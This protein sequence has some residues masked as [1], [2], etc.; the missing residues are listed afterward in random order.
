MV[1]VGLVICPCSLCPLVLLVWNLGCTSSTLWGLLLGP[2]YL[3][4]CWIWL[5][6]VQDLQLCPYDHLLFHVQ[7]FSFH[8]VPITSRMVYNP[9]LTM[10]LSRSWTLR[11]CTKILLREHAQ[12][13]T[14]HLHSPQLPSVL[15]MCLVTWS[16]WQGCLYCSLELPQLFLSLGATQNGQSSVLPVL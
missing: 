14:Q 5:Y 11:V 2:L 8:Q 1:G 10:A 4:T 6:L 16:K 12:G 3:M 13:S 9:L 7:T 15:E